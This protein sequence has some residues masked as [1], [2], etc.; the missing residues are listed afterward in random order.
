M[1]FKVVDFF[2]LAHFEENY[3]CDLAFAMATSCKLPN[4]E[5]LVA[6]DESIFGIE[7]L[8]LG[9]FSTRILHLNAIFVFVVFRS[10]RCLLLTHT[11]AHTSITYFS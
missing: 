7:M 11:H 8:S 10:P 4:A 6:F 1:L 5:H 9:F 2:L 3:L